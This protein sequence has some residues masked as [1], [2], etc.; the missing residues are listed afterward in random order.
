M[1]WRIS[2]AWL[3]LNRGPVWDHFSV[4]QRLGFV[5]KRCNIREIGF[6]KPVK[7]VGG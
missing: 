5:P 2:K 6:I 4:D 1:D 7:P 3:L